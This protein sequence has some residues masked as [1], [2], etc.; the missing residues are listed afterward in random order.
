MPG[1][2]GGSTSAAPAPKLQQSELHTN[3]ACWWYL[4]ET[5]G[6]ELGWVLQ[7]ERPAVLLQV[8]GRPISTDW[9]DP[10]AGPDHL[11]GWDVD[12]AACLVALETGDSQRS[13]SVTRGIAGLKKLCGLGGGS[14]GQGGDRGD[15]PRAPAQAWI[16]SQEEDWRSWVMPE[17]LQGCSCS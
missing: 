8:L 3:A 5:K 9:Q 2:A 14:A 12:P 6:E 11:G 10:G 7:R 17:D 16:L 15:F 1:L 13:I 4:E